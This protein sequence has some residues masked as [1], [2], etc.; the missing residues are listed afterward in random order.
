MEISDAVGPSR[1]TIMKGAAWSAPVI[2]AALS[3]PLSAASACTDWIDVETGVEFADS[4]NLFDNYQRKV[5]T[6]TV[7]PN[8]TL[9]EFDVAGGGGGV[10]YNPDS[11]THQPGGDGHRLRGTLTVVPGTML[12]LI[13]GNGG[14][15]VNVFGDAP[16]FASM[17]A[18]VKEIER[19]ILARRFRAGR[20]PVLR[21]NLA[22][23][24]VEQDAAGNVKFAKHRAV[25]KIDGAVACAM[26]IGRALANES[27]PM[28]YEREGARPEGFLAI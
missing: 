10:N 18:P 23:V 27:G 26:A 24:R 6:F 15:G 14:I 13:A 28:V 2:A 1:R 9:I 22:N 12:T 20:D 25:G 5:T 4:S 21:W 19:A 16:A 17:S 3:A 11:G 7:P 8:V